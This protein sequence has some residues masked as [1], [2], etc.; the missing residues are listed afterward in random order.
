MSAGLTLEPMSLHRAC[1]SL[2][3]C[4][5][6]DV[7]VLPRDEVAGTKLSAHRDQSVHRHLELC[8]N[9]LRDITLT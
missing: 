1:E 6:G 5:S 2:A 7:H 8:L 3:L 9:T 4:R